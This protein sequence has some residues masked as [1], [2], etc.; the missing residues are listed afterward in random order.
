MRARTVIRVHVGRSAQSHRSRSPARP[1]GSRSARPADD[2]DILDVGVDRT[3]NPP[4][5]RHRRPGVE[6]DSPNRRRTGQDGARGEPRP[7]NPAWLAFRAARGHLHVHELG[8]PGLRV[9]ML[10]RPFSRTASPTAVTT[11]GPGQAPP[12]SLCPRG[13]RQ[14]TR[15]QA[16]S[17]R[18]GPV[19][20]GCPEPSHRRSPA[21]AEPSGS[22]TTRCCPARRWSASRRG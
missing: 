2:Q 14:S 3:M 11:A 9:A 21:A 18:L 12:R 8:E 1:R 7:F 6:H 19:S 20:R 5:R 10:Q 16:T 17:G 4:A 22:G 15:A 13:P